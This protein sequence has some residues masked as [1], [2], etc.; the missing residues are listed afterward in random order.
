M[1][2]HRSALGAALCVA[3]AGCGA[4]PL[5]LPAKASPAPPASP[6]CPGGLSAPLIAQPQ[7]SAEAGMVKAQTQAESD[8]Q[9]ASL[10]WIHDLAAWG[11]AG[12][13]RAGDAQAWC[14]RH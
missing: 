12:W 4:I 9:A 7:P 13:A 8:A 14:T 11:R 10:T 6:V 3:L 1:S 5:R 2:L